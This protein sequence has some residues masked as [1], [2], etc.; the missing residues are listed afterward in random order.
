MSAVQSNEKGRFRLTTLV[1]R[2]EY[3]RTV[4]RRGY[5]FGT[6]LLPFGIAALMAISTFFSVDSFED[7]GQVSGS[8]VIVNTSDMTI[9][10]IETG[11]VQIQTLSSEEAAASLA[12][13]A[14]SEYYVIP[15]DFR[16][17]RGITRIEPP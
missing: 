1:A 3:L 10:D 13:G 2:R 15:E 11:P 16:S 8:I 7:D 4:R 9:E 5:V 14:I 12:D 6:L 17:E